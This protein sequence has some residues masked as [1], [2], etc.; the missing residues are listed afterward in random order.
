MSEGYGGGTGMAPRN[1]FR[2]VG[3]ECRCDDYFHKD[4][5]SQLCGGRFIVTSQLLVPTPGIATI[6]MRKDGDKIHQLM[7]SL[8]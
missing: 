2:D 6:V 4:A 8:T 1:T 7:M 5:D 3:A